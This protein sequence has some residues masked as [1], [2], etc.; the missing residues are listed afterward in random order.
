MVLGAITDANKQ[1][2]WNQNAVS[3]TFESVGLLAE[4]LSELFSTSRSKPRLKAA[5][6]GSVPRRMLVMLR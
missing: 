2:A 6:L 4:S 5:G 1:S 3:L